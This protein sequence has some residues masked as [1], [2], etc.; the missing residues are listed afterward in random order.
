MADLGLQSTMYIA[1]DYGRC[2]W[3]SIG[4]PIKYFLKFRMVHIP[5]KSILGFPMNLCAI[6]SSSNMFPK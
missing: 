5:P 1:T 4:T 6:Y 2:R 3:I